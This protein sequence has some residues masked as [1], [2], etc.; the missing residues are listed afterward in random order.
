V[1]SSEDFWV[2][3]IR[4]HGKLVSSGTARFVVALHAPEGTGYPPQQFEVVV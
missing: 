2:E 1:D 4:A 3:V